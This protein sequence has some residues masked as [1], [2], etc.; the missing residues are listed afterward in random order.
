VTY[1]P[2]PEDDDLA[3]AAADAFLAHDPGPEQRGYRPTGN[4][5]VTARLPDPSMLPPDCLAA[6]VDVQLR[7]VRDLVK[8][9]EALR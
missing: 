8:G 1:L 6:C 9:I 7:R 4:V 5:A 2:P 3:A